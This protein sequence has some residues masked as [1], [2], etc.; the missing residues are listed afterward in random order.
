MDSCGFWDSMPVNHIWVDNVERCS[1]YSLYDIIYPLPSS[2]ITITLSKGTSEL[3]QIVCSYLPLETP[4]IVCSFKTHCICVGTFWIAKRTVPKPR[5][6]RSY[7]YRSL[8]QHFTSGNILIFGTFPLSSWSSKTIF[9]TH[10]KTYRHHHCHA[11]FHFDDNE[12][13]ITKSAPSIEWC[14]Q[15]QQLITNHILDSDDTC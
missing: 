7:I 1:H 4:L 9:I 6:I 13:E 12:V 10:S 14:A 5:H 15:S 2:S 8:S 11:F 3:K